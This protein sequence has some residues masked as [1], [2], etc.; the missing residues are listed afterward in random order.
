MAYLRPSDKPP[1]DRETLDLLARLVG[2][3]LPEEDIDP[4]AAALRDQLEAADVLS[5]LDLTDTNPASSFDA[6]WHE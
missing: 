3:T 1:I 6:H 2:L 5:V 4:L